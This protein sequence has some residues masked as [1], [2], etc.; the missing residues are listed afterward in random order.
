MFFKQNVT[1]VSVFIG[2][3]S[4][5]LF[6]HILQYLFVHFA[7]YSNLC[8]CMQG[9]GRHSVALNGEKIGTLVKIAFQTTWVREQSY[10]KP[11]GAKLSCTLLNRPIY[12][13][14]RS[15][16][17]V[18]FNPCTFHRHVDSVPYIT[19][20]RN[21]IRYRPIYL[22]SFFLHCH[23]SNRCDSGKKQGIFI[24]PIRA[25]VKMKKALSHYAASLVA[26]R[27]EYIKN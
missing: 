1:H 25:D 18:S 10:N 24:I 19:L 8:P 22:L 12:T 17:A 3:K 5:C 7:R 15:N 26:S 6:I 2:T 9:L 14:S 11:G 4:I 16:C 21:D 13:S 23:S 20:L 27:R